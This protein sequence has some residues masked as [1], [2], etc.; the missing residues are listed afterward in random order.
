MLALIQKRYIRLIVFALSS[1]TA[2]Y[3]P[4]VHVNNTFIVQDWGF[5]NSLS[6]VIRSSIFNYGTFPIHDPWVNG[7]VDMIANPQTRI[8]SPLIICDLL[9]FAPLANIMSL[10]ITG[11][12]GS[13]GFYKLLC[14]LKTDKG[15]AVSGAIVFIH[16]SWF[17]LHYSEGHVSFGGFML[18]GLTYYCILRIQEA[19]FK[20]YYALLMAFFWLDGAIYTF[21]FSNLLLVISLLIQIHNLKIKTFGISIVRQWKSTLFA[22]FLFLSISGAKLFPF[23]MFYTKREP[24][25][26]N[27]QFD[28]KTI[29]TAFFDPF[30]HLNKAFHHTNTIFI[31]FHE[32]GAYIGIVSFILLAIYLIKTFKDKNNIKYLSIAL[33]FLWI[34]AGWI[35][36]LN[37]WILFQKIPIVN[38]AHMQCRYLFITYFVSIILVF[39]AIQ[40][41]K[42]IINKNI[43]T[44]I[45]VFLIAEALFVNN[46]TYFKVFKDDPDVYSTEIFKSYINST[47]IEKTVKKA[48]NSWGYKFMHYA[49]TNTGAQFANDPAAIRG[50]LS[51]VEDSSYRGEAYFIKGSGTT[52]LL[53]Y[54]PGYIKLNY[55]CD[56]LP[57]EIQLNTNFLLGWESKQGK[58]YSKDGLL[59]FSPY[60]KEQF[61]ILKYAP[62]YWPWNVFIFLIGICSML[63]FLINKK[64]FYFIVNN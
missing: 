23:L 62:T 10:V 17:G 43:T 40:Y 28:I 54:T 63:L 49:K 35:P 53:I 5:F 18:F 2:F 51:S 7:G 3:L 20:I 27:L 48:T 57:C 22:S 24:I 19:P 32:I 47:T 1:I 13:I 29:L 38:N 15:I 39:K 34:G 33:F 55:R 9:F 41:F 8:F 4:L 52:N 30:Q 42:P 21:I 31:R 12:I 26:E 11:F 25:L 44:G 46:Y 6:H 37:P 60:K 61:A 58:T 14:Y 45:L 50:K 59:T 56:T 36:N 64:V 16:A